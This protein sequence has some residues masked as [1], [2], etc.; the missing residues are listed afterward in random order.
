MKKMK[1]VNIP[2]EIT[3]APYF[4]K[5]EYE[6]LVV[7]RMD[8]LQA[9]GWTKGNAYEIATSLDYEGWPIDYR[10]ANDLLKKIGNEEDVLYLLV[11]RKVK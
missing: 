9:G 7:W 5:P 8:M 2:V 3:E 4:E 6:K 1:T 11:D 10:K